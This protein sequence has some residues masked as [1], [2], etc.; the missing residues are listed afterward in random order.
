MTRRRDLSKVIELSWSFCCN[1]LTSGAL[2][3]WINRCNERRETEV[4]ERHPHAGESLD[5][6]YH[7]HVDFMYIL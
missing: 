7:F 3:R 5:E 4:R 6:V 1:V 2:M